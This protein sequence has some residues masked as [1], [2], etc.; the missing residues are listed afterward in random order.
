MVTLFHKIN[1]QKLWSIYIKTRPSEKSDEFQSG[2]DRTIYWIIPTNKTMLIWGRLFRSKKKRTHSAEYLKTIRMT[3]NVFTWKW[4]YA[5]S[6]VRISLEI[7]EE[8]LRKKK[9]ACSSVRS[10]IAGVLGKRAWSQEYQW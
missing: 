5:W 3:V 7:I 9:N 10:S 6:E 4:R 1:K 8:S 2:V